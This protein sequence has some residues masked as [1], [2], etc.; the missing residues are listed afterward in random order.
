MICLY[1]ALYPY[2]DKKTRQENNLLM[3]QYRQKL[4]D[5][6]FI[7]HTGKPFDE[8]NI[9]KAKNGK[10]YLI[11]SSLFFNISHTNGL[12]CCGISDSEIGVDC[13]CIRDFNIKLLDKVC[14]HDEKQNILG[15]N[16]IKTSFFTH[17][18]LKESYCKFTGQGISFNFRNIDFSL[19]DH[20]IQSA[21]DDIYFDVKFIDRFVISVCSA[22]KYLSAQHKYYSIT[23][24]KYL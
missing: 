20:N 5:T 17:W 18:V 23:N 9:I 6:V 22:D 2:D 8:Q 4:L 21:R 24:C 12:I 15:S 7:K 13:E 16:D 11:D 19:H 3:K 1:Y 14:T 10:P